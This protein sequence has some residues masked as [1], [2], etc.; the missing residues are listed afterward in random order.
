MAELCTPP[1]CGTSEGE[2]PFGPLE[3]MGS[4][5][6]VKTRGMSQCSHCAAGIGWIDYDAVA[7]FYSTYTIQ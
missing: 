7:G 6:A 4:P 5:D 3:G 1:R 2:S